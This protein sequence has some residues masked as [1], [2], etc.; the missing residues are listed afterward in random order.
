MTER[1]LP[2]S[3]IQ[4]QFWLAQELQRETTAYHIATLWC[5]R[6]RLKLES[7]WAAFEQL[8]RRH[9]GLRTTF[10]ERETTL[11]Q[12]IH[13]DLTPEFCVEH[14]HV[15]VGG[16]CS[17]RGAQAPVR[18]GARP[19]R[20]GS[21]LCRLRRRKCRGLDDAPHRVRPGQQGSDGCGV[22]QALPVALPG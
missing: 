19:A 20:A 2:A 17:A 14:R 9:E 21:G 13:S 15:E 16:G 18:P 5:I 8:C 7:L 1:L 22:V 4:R 3:G 12:V 10:E 6:G 11:Y